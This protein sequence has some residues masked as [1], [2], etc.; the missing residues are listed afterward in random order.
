ME[1]NSRF[2]NRVSRYGFSTNMSKCWVDLTSSSRTV[3]VEREEVSS[4]R[5]KPLYI[6][7]GSKRRKVFHPFT[8][9]KYS[10]GKQT[11]GHVCASGSPNYVGYVE[12]FPYVD[13]N[14]TLT[15]AWRASHPTKWSGDIPPMGWEPLAEIG[16]D[17]RE[18][19]IRDLFSKANAPRWNASV[20]M[21]ELDETL[22]GIHGLFKNCLQSAWRLKYTRKNIKHLFLNPEELWLW[23]R[24]M[25]V[26]T[27]LDVEELISALNTDEVIDRVQDGDR[28]KEPEKRNGTLERLGMGYGQFNVPFHWEAEINYG[29]GGAIDMLSRKDLSPWGTSAHDVLMGA[30]ERIP[31][32][33]LVDWF[34]NVGDWLASL[35]SI[36][37][38][39]AQS[40]ATYSVASTVKV[41]TDCGVYVLNE[42]PEYYTH[43][44]NRIVDLEPPKLPLIDRRWANITRY[45][46]LIALSTGML[47]GILRRK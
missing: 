12:E 31:F 17:L 30:W 39:Y 24:Y 35:R 34:I 28:P 44:M 41:D 8:K 45:I 29:I 38:V 33:F 3:E 26:P 11:S 21:A 4:Y 18:F 42:K 14:E 36:E 27:I 46:D 16:N 9:Y 15:E 19:V 37:V 5:G 20:F 2:K 32:S 40:Y 13:I 10:A 23:Y 22:V 1:N 43:V 47:K 7:V 6:D 25:L